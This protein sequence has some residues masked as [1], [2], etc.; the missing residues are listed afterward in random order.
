MK[1]LVDF[2]NEV[3]KLK[4]MPR[5][6]WVLRN[7]KNPESIAGHTFRTAIIAWLL[8]EQRRGL[9]IEKVIK[10]ALIHDLCEIY[11]GDTTPY[12]SILPKN[13]KKRAQLLNVWPRF[14]PAEK[15]AL[16][17]KKYKKESKALERLI[18]KLPC[19]LK[20]EIRKLWIDYEKCLSPEGRFFHQADRIENFLQAVEYRA[21]D[22]KF[23]QKPW[24]V[25]AGEFFDDPVLLDFIKEVDKKFSKK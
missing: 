14:S 1:H 9:N 20:K 16:A 10:M 23:P 22:K 11:A 6:G 5:R 3:G 8:G 12:D 13:K 4:E 25:W 18:S 24:W 15:K 21:R 7:V 17:E 19:D 2:F